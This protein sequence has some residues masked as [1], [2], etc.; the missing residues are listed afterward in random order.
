MK[1]LVLAM[2]CVLSL[3]LLAS[4]KQAASTQ[5]V[6][7]KNQAAT[8]VSTYKLDVTGTFALQTTTGTGTSTA[9][10]ADTT[11]NHATLVPSDA[12]GFSEITCDINRDK[13]DAN[14][15]QWTLKVMFAH[16]TGASGAANTSAKKTFTIYKLGD[17]YYIDDYKSS[18]FT[19]GRAELTVTGSLDD[20]EFTIAS[21]GFISPDNSS[22]V[23]S[24]GS[25]TFKR[26]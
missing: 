26:K 3:A 20:A 24:S 16:N 4:C 11:A 12:F 13:V 5:D 21:L 9:Y 1:K 2:A 7:L 18:Y 25:I 22:E 17:K 14:Y 15:K 10:T 23:Y 6:N 8:E 19:T